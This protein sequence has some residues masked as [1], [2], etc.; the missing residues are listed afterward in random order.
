M[1]RD[2][3]AERNHRGIF[4]VL[5]TGALPFHIVGKGRMLFVARLE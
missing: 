1:T 2:A 3:P 5:V 4:Q